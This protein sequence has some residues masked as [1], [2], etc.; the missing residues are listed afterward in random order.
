MV[1][2]VAVLGDVHGNALA[3]Q[4]VLAELGGEKVDLVVWMGDLSWGAEP[5]SALDL[6]RAL[7]LPSRFVQG[8]AERAL[9]E[10]EEGTNA[11]PSERERWM[12]AAHTAEDLEFARMFE[13]FHTVEIEGLGG[14][15]F[16]HCSPRSDEELLTAGTPEERVA[17]ATGEIGERVLVIGHTHSQYDREVAGVRAINGGSV[18]MPYESL[19]GAYWA[20]LGP[21]VE[22]RHTEYDLAAAAERMRA[23]GFPDCEPLVETLLEPPTPAE[24]IAQAEKLEFSG[25]SSV[26][27]IS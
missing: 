3:L 27:R 26:R 12:L 1:Q 14:V 16:T 4:A 6:V 7:E 22:L 8:N 2:R 10:L 13:P 19:P 18:G 24:M 9:L 17:A 11:A 5:T 21:G 25:R 23:S 20:L 15:Y